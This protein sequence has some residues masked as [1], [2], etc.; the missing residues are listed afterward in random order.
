MLSLSPAPKSLANFQIEFVLHSEK[1]AVIDSLGFF[2]QNMF[3]ER[4]GIIDLR[5][6]RY[7]I[8][9]KGK[10]NFSVTIFNNPLI[11]GGYKL[12]LF[13]GSNLLSGNFPDIARFHIFTTDRTDNLVSY[14]VEVR[15]KVEFSYVFNNS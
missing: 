2:V 10:L 14:P 13:L 12:G 7:K 1:P 6:E 9:K 8:D 5:K 11:E 4:V 15:G 3:E